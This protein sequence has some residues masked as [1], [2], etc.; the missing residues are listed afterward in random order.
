M[1]I[2]FQLGTTFEKQNTSSHRIA[3]QGNI[4][5]I[6]IIIIIA[7]VWKIINSKYKIMVKFF[8]S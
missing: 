7:H 3:Q 2:H 8:E 4:M 1:D 6:I 5:I